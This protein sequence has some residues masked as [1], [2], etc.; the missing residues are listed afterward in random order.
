MCLILFYQVKLFIYREPLESKL[1]I[2]STDAR[3]LQIPGQC[4]ALD[5]HA[6]DTLAYTTATRPSSGNMVPLMAPQ[7][8]S[9]MND[10]IAATHTPPPR[11]DDKNN[12]SPI[13]QNKI[14]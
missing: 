1:R 2:G 3:L 9:N 12:L 6:Y 5:H 11:K 14:S 4:L 8:I 13:K 10:P 7:S